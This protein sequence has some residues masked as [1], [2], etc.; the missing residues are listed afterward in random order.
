MHL[1]HHSWHENTMGRW[2][3]GGG[4]SIHYCTHQ[5]RGNKSQECVCCG[6]YLCTN[7][8]SKVENLYCHS[9]NI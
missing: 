5:V 8:W 1:Y 6:S 2:G 4:G 7:T 9:M 3:V